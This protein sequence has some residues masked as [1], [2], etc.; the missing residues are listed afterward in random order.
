MGSWW[1][2]VDTTDSCV[3]FRANN[4]V[5][6]SNFGE[7]AYRPVQ[8]LQSAAP[9]VIAVRVRV[10]AKASGTAELDALRISYVAPQR[11]GSRD[12]GSVEVPRSSVRR[13]NLSQWSPALVS[14]RSGIILNP[15][16]SMNGTA[17]ESQGSAEF[18]KC[19]GR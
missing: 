9:E 4:A 15:P 19:N 17:G 11:L 7:W 12:R 5:F 18:D 2:T 8:F 13:R 10:S 3:P 14:P 6:Q 1:A 16:V